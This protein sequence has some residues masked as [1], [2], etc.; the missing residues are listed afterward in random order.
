MTRRGVFGA[1]NDQS[2]IA[3][4]EETGLYVLLI[5]EGHSAKFL[6][7][8]AAPL[9]IVSSLTKKNQTVASANGGYLTVHGNGKLN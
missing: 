9:S 5:L 4:I 2:N 7:D 8:T 1:R 3:I 6:A